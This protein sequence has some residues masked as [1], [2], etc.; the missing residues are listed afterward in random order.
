MSP[1][2]PSPLDNDFRHEESAPWSAP[3][4][5]DDVHLTVIT[6]ATGTALA[7]LPHIPEAVIYIPS[8][9]APEYVA[10]RIS[11][12]LLVAEVCM[13]HVAAPNFF[14]PLRPE[15]LEDKI[16]NHLFISRMVELNQTLQAGNSIQRNRI[17]SWSMYFILLCCVAMWAVLFSK[18]IVPVNLWTLSVMNVVFVMMLQPS[19]PK[20]LNQIK[21]AVAAWS[22]ADHE[23]GINLAYLV[24]PDRTFNANL[25]ISVAI[26]FYEKVT[27]RGDGSRGVV[28]ELPAYAPH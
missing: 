17:Y 26:S 15:V 1:A 20:Y 19:K 6:P 22:K 2:L 24:K 23:L 10:P 13:N 21:T 7:P 25:Y 5:F 8:E 18:G 9:P 4:D 12:L 28:E 27:E 16:P 14:D 3:P 11:D